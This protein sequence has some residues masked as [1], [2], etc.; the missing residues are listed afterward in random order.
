VDPLLGLK[1]NVIIGKLIPAGTGMSR[2]RNIKVKPKHVG[3]SLLEEVEALT[4][5]TGRTGAPTVEELENLFGAEAVSAVLEADETDI[6]ELE[7]STRTKNML[8]AANVNTRGDLLRLSEDDLY[9]AGLGKSNVEELKKSGLLKEIVLEEAG[10]EE[11]AE[12]VEEAEE[13]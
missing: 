13:I 4:T 12:E 9:E 8:K 2:Y 11:E 7:L 5:G 6:A 10:E 3:I 1:E